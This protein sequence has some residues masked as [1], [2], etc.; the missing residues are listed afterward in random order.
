MSI[1]TLIPSPGDFDDLEFAAIV[2]DFHTD[3]APT[4]VFERGADGDPKPARSIKRSR[5]ARGDDERAHIN[6]ELGYGRHR[7]G[8]VW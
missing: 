5:P 2:A 8:E 6:A 4:V 7:T 1:S 3:A